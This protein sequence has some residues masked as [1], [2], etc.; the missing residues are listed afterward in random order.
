MRNEAVK[1]TPLWHWWFCFCK[2]NE[3]L[4]TVLWCC[5]VDEVSAVC[6]SNAAIK[7]V[8]IVGLETHVCVLQTA[9]DLL[10]ELAW[11]W[12]RVF[13]WF[14]CLLEVEVLTVGWRRMFCVPQ[15][16]LLG[17]SFDDWEKICR[18]QVG[19]SLN[20]FLNSWN[21]F[22]TTTAPYKTC[23]QHEQIPWPLF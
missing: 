17:E 6:K 23:P 14:L 13:L 15:T 22:N 10:G 19:H 2:V 12:I 18:G 21:S 16:C 1:E 3:G 5:A 8:L 11:A 7:Q 20:L 4:K 9:L